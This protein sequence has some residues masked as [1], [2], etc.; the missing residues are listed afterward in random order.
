[1]LNLSAFE[2]MT[3][4]TDF[5]MGCVVVY[6]LVQIRTWRGFKSTIWTWA[7][8]LLAVAS[9]MGVVAHGL[10]MS[11]F[12]NKLLWQP[13]NLLLGLALGFFVV[14][15]VFDFWGE[16]TARKMIPVM[17]VLGI[18]FYLMTVLI[19]GTFLTFIA[20]ETLAMFFA[21]GVY[22]ILTVKKSLPGAGWMT[23]GILVTIIAAVVQAVYQNQQSI[24]WYFDNNGIFHLIQIVGLLLLLRGLKM[25]LAANNLNP[26]SPRY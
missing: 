19:P 7:F 25:G 18:V 14:G 3:A 26:S 23:A 15:A 5:V 16:S 8:G 17:V 20:Y 1:M 6:V 2:R 22:I 12:T 24:I 10:A 13:L 4:L 11:D 21:L 9:F